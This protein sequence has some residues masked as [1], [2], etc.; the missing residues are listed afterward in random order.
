MAAARPAGPPP[1]M[2]TLIPCP[3]CFE[4]DI[5]DP[6]VVSLG[7]K[8][9]GIEFV[10]EKQGRICFQGFRAHA[11][12]MCYIVVGAIFGNARFYAGWLM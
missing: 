3:N 10:G 7:K 11:R 4:V 6:D 1:M 8:S 2:T 9:N 5:L 12:K